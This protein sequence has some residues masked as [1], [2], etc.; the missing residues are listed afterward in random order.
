MNAF[1]NSY[2]FEIQHNLSDDGHSDRIQYTHVMSRGRTTEKHYGQ[3][4]RLCVNQRVVSFVIYV[5]DVQITHT[6]THL[7]ALF[8]G[9]WVLLKQETEWQ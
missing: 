9:V 7:M 3:S 8:L 2:H 1:V 4:G 5:I 6:H